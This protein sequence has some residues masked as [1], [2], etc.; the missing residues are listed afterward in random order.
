MT[1]A[2]DAAAAARGKKEELSLEYGLTE[3]DLHML[4]REA[5]PP[6]AS[7]A[8]PG[9]SRRIQPAR[10]P[11]HLGRPPCRLQS[12]QAEAVAEVVALGSRPREGGEKPLLTLYQA[13][14]PR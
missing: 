12:V 14:S 4:E 7:T 5:R 8:P 6:R 3:A 13:S 2:A 11:R 9:P 1:S 10:A